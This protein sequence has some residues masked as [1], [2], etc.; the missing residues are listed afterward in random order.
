MLTRP[1]RAI[2]VSRAKSKSSGRAL[3]IDHVSRC[4][5]GVCARTRQGRA[6][7][8]ITTAHAIRRIEIAIGTPFELFLEA[9]QQAP[10]PIDDASSRDR[11]VVEI[12]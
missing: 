4:W 8:A 5:S 10:Q 12:S 9:L 3:F 11:A 7:T 1:R 2:I 6:P